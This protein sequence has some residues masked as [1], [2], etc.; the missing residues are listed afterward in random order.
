[1][2]PLTTAL[3]IGARNRLG[4]AKTGAETVRN[5]LRHGLIGPSHCQ[6]ARSGQ[7]V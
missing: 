5:R 3:T 4:C 6:A 1:M 7:A 2:A